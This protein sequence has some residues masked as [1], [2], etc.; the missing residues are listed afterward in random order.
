MNID[1]PD[2]QF[3]IGTGLSAAL[4]HHFALQYPVQAP[5]VETLRCYIAAIPC[6]AA[7]SYYLHGKT[8]LLDNLSIGLKAYSVYVFLLQFIYPDCSSSSPFFSKQSTTS[9]SAIEAFQANFIAKPLIGDYGQYTAQVVPI[10]G[11]KPST[12]NTVPPYPWQLSAF[13]IY[14]LSSEGISC[15]SSLII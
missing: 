12:S 15:G 4:L 1:I 8:N 6:F 13:Y 7:T 11:S 5:F 14:V 2:N 3:I 9:F 10:D